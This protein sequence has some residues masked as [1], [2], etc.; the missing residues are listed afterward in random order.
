MQKLRKFNLEKNVIPNRLKKYMSF[1]LNNKLSF[2]DCFQFLM[3]SLGSLVK[4]LD[5]NGFRYL[6]QEIENNVLDLVRQEGFYPY[7]HIRN[8]EKFKEQLPNREKFCSFLTSKKNSDKDY[9]HVLKSWNEIDMKT[10][11][12]YHDLDLKCDVLVL[13]DA[14]EKFKNSSLKNY[15]LCLNHHL[16]KPALSWDVICFVKKLTL[17][18]LKMLHVFFLFLKRYERVFLISRDIA[19]P[20]LSI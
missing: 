5:K 7:E 4:N 14:G 17:N 12:E 16:S 6:N 10:M 1:S 19:K 20:A 13:R 18:L 3:S 2:I 9:E 15:E 8:Y 11:K